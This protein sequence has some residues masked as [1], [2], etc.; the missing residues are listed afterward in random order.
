MEKWNRAEWSGTFFMYTDHPSHTPVL[1]LMFRDATAARGIFGGLRTRLGEVDEKRALRI[2]VI[3]GISAANPAHYA[4]VVGSHLDASDLRSSRQFMYVSR[5]H[6]MRP[7][8]D[9]NLRGFLEAYRKSGRYLLVPAILGDDESTADPLMDRAIGKYEL[10]VRDAW[11][12]GPN[13]P[14]IIVI[15]PDDPPVIPPVVIDP[16]VLRA[17][18]WAKSR[19]VGKKCRKRQRGW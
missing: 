9:A 17:L 18:E 13:D 2:T 7:Q 15:D 5:I 12:I 8:T 6:R 14:D 3:R 10:D 4:V 19:K 16:P 1:G 11:Q